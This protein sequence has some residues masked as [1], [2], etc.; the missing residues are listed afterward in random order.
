V[1]GEKFFIKTVN[2]ESNTYVSMQMCVCV[3]SHVPMI[4]KQDVNVN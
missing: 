2:K 1:T 4:L 3:W